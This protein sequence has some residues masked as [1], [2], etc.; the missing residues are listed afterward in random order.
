MGLSRRHFLQAAATAIGGSAALGL[1]AWQVEPHWVE[2]VRRPLPL[3]GLPRALQGATLLQVSDLHVGHRVS[4]SYLRDT[5]RGARALNPD[6]VVVTGDFI[7]WRRG[8]KWDQL[9]RVLE[10]LPRGR[11]GTLAILGNHDYGPSWSDLGVADRVHAVLR[12]QRIVLLRNEVTQV[13]G[14]T[15]AGLEDFWCPNFAPD[16]VLGSLPPGRSSLILNHNPDAVDLP[17]FTPVTGW[18]LAG[19][20]HGG[21]CKPPFLPPPILPVRNKRYTAGAFALAAGRSMYINRALGHLIQVRFNVR[22]ELTLFT[23]VEAGDA[24]RYLTA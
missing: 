24:A 8:Y 7:A 3:A 19:H 16:Q 23:L 4:E 18:V 5:L 12:E 17:V 20:T 6:L 21:Q 14:L 15:V 10:Q 11:L 13:G 9:S 1:Y 2:T 22:P